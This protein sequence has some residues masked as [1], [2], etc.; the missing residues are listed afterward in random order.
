MP[1]KP[2]PQ[3]SKQAPSGTGMS[4]KLANTCAQFL[5]RLAWTHAI[6]LVVKDVHDDLAR[7]ATLYAR[8]HCMVPLLTL[9]GMLV[10]SKPCCA[11]SRRRSWSC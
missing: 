10:R 2:K 5:E 1:P 11:P 8:W 7:E 4:D 9:A 6:P 3:K